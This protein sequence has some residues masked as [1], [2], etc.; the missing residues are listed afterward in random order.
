MPAGFGSATA[1]LSKK[2]D[3]DASTTTTKFPHRI[4]L[5]TNI[6]S[7]P[8]PKAMTFIIKSVTMFGALI[9]IICAQFLTAFTPLFTQKAGNIR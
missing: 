2:E 1:T 8:F 7:G 5:L 3:T 6:G 9:Q 4:G